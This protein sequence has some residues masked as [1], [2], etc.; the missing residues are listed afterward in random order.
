MRDLTG[1]RDTHVWKWWVES[2]RNAARVLAEMK[3]GTQ[4]RERVQR[5]KSWTN[6]PVGKE[7]GDEGLKETLPRLTRE[8]K[9]KI[10]CARFITQ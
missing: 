1:E 4:R 9:G 8:E 10:L 5:R 6:D 3:R 2:I 7:S